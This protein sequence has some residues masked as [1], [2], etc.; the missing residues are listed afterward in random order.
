MTIDTS[1]PGAS[2][3][4][5]VPAAVPASG[6]ERACLAGGLVI[7]AFAWTG[8]L[9]GWSAEYFTGHMVLHVVLIAIVAPLLAAGFARRLPRGARPV[10]AAPLLAAAFEFVVM[11]G[12]HLPAAHEWA[13]GSAVGF[14]LEQGAFLAAG[15]WVWAAALAPGAGLPGSVALL[16]TSMHVTL[17]GA[18]VTLPGRAI[19]A[20]CGGPALSPL[21]DQTLGGTLMLAVATP[22]YLLGGLHV[23]RRGLREGRERGDGLTREPTD[24]AG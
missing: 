23:A 14:A 17:L 24:R 22:I 7:L 12:W 5:S 19:Y 21:A 9:R 1:E 16:G 2:P 6:P 4:A 15:T 18:I 10:L 3:P 20:T 13:R 11:W 8:P